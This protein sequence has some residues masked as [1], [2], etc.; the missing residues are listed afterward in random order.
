V[1]APRERQS[2]ELPDHGPGCR[3]LSGLCSARFPDEP[4][5]VCT[6]NCPRRNALAREYDAAARSAAYPLVLV[7]FKDNGEQEIAASIDAVLSKL[8][9]SATAG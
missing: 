6:P 1:N 5:Y 2:V 8:D 4:R 3:P 7:A 9:P